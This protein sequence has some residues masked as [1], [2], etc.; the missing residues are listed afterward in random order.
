MIDRSKIAIISTV[1]NFNLYEKTS[2]YFPNGIRKYI[3]DGRNKM[4]G[5][6]SILFMI[7]KLKNRGIEWLI[8]ADEDVIFID[9]EIV[10][11]IIKN[12]KSNNIT[13]SGVRDG[14]VINHRNYNPNVINTFFSIVNFKKIE[15]YWKKDEMLKN[16]YIIKSEFHDEL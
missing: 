8:M 9:S 4:Y 11:D 15:K 3:I 5:I 6:D 16:Q 7:K 14:G 13:V 10:F 2:I 1:I 12:M